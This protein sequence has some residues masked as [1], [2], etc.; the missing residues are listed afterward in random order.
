MPLVEGMSFQSVMRR[1]EF[2][3]LELRQSIRRSTNI[4][5][6][7]EYR[8]LRPNATNNPIPAYY[9]SSTCFL[10]RP[11]LRSIF[12]LAG[13]ATRHIPPTTSALTAA[14]PSRPPT[15]LHRPNDALSAASPGQ[16]K[17]HRKSVRR[18]D[19]RGSARPNA[20]RP[21]RPKFR[22]IH[23]R[24]DGPD[25]L[26]G[27]AES[28]DGGAGVYGAKRTLPFPRRPSPYQHP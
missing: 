21:I 6:S 16:L 25:G 19:G 18:P 20:R 9:I 13:N 12:E 14:P 27:W 24:P 15:C 8:V 1:A 3:D 28:R 2:N 7:K 5:A 11:A 4:Q 22:R 26:P 10:K 17:L 23:E